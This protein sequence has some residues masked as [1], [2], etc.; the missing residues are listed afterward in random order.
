ML[1]PI[2]LS[3]ELMIDLDHPQA[4]DTFQASAIES[5]IHAELLLVR[6]AK[7]SANSSGWEERI[8]LELTPQLHQLN[9]QHF[10]NSPKIRQTIEALEHAVRRSDHDQ[11]WNC[12][13]DM[14]NNSGDNS[15]TW[16][17]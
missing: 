6:D 12:L 7:G 15:G 17:I 4:Q 13:M 16:A 8:C 11:A 2:S 5:R 1:Q 10:G 9:E 3:E 14:M